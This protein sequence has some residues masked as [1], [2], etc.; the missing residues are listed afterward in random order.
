MIRCDDERSVIKVFTDG[1]RDEFEIRSDEG[2]LVITVTLA[3]CSP[4]VA[5]RV[6]AEIGDRAEIFRFE[7]ERGP[8]YDGNLCQVNGALT[9]RR[10]LFLRVT[11]LLADP[12]A[13]EAVDVVL[14]LFGAKLPV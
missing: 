2:H 12:H 3:T 14:S 10:R 9:G 11:M 5:Q 8:K 13:F 4:T 6:F 1:S 7:V